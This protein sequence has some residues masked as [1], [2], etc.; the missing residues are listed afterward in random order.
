MSKAQSLKQHLKRGGVYR[1]SDLEQWSKA[2][3]RELAELIKDGTLQKVATGI[4]HYPRKNAF[5]QE[6]P[7]ET[8]LIK[9][10]LK[11]D[12][13]LITSYNQFNGLGLGT[14]Q[15]YNEK[16]VYNHS[17]S[18][19]YRLGNNKFIFRKKNLFPDQTSKEF[20]LIDLLN[21]L[22]ELAE[23]QPGILE[24]VYKKIADFNTSNLRNA[25]REFGTAKTR[26][27]LA[28]LI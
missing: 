13:F 9:K 3:D 17:R 18:G 14:T 1:R 4:Y 28:S 8:K 20:L 27:L 16:I 5:G 11:S 12:K 21:N 25:L 6:P 19:E 15:L 10:F 2:I 24:R 26:K 23:D 22:N 7:E